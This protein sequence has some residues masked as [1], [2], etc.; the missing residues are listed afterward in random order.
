M[1]G[2]LGLF[3]CVMLAFPAATPAEA[4]VNINISVGSNISNGRS[5]TCQE[6]RDRLRRH[7]FRD[8]RTVDCR[9]RF[10]VYRATRDGRR[11]EIALNRN[12]GRVVDMR[13][14]GR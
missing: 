3:L 5:I 13:R 1:R 10:F 4:Q 8:I 6:G 12:N 11:F 2:L 9:G 14:V 7:R